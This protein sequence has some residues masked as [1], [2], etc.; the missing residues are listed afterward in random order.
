LLEG[1]FLKRLRGDAMA[2]EWTLMETHGLVLFLIASQPDLTMR[3]IA[4]TLGITERRVNQ[5]V[6]DL[7]GADLVRKTKLGR[8]NFYSLNPD[9]GFR[10]PTLS[11]VT[12]G[13]FIEV[14]QGRI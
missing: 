10:H 6:Q 13:K 9:A 8:R 11:H 12:L 2:S 4:E 14:L 3:A 7:A 5:I 1:D